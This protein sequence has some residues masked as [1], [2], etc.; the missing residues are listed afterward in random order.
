MNKLFPKKYLALIVLVAIGS[1]ADEFFARA[2]VLEV[3]PIGDS[4]SSV[5]VPITPSCDRRKPAEGAGLMATLRWDLCTAP[6]A[7][8]GEARSYRVVYEWDDRVYERVMKHRP[9]E[10]V[11]VRVYIDGP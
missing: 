9:G 3:I 1:T 11:P 6:P 7:V 5:V 4:S 2:R 10:T 8:R